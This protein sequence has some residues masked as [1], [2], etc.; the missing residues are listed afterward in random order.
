MKN[1]PIIAAVISMLMLCSCGKTKV[2]LQESITVPQT[3]STTASEVAEITETET[4]SKAAEATETETTSETVTSE[5]LMEI[6]NYDMIP[7]VE[8]ATYREPPAA[9]IPENMEFT[10]DLKDI[11]P[12][13]DLFA[14]TNME[15]H[16][17]GETFKMD[18][19]GDGVEEEISVDED[20]YKIEGKLRVLKVIIDGKTYN[21]DRSHEGFMNVPTGIFTCDIDSSD[22]YIEIACAG[23]IATNDYLTV[24]FRY[25]NGE[26]REIFDIRYDTPDGSGESDMF[27]D[28]MNQSVTGKPIITDGSGV[29]TAARRLDAQTWLAYSHYAYDSESGEISFF[30]EPVY[31]YYY[32]NINSF[33]M[34]MEFTSEWYIPDVVPERPMPKSLKEITLY[35]EP[36]LNSETVTLEPQECYITAEYFSFD[37]A[38]IYL[39]AKDGK[40]GW[41][42]LDETIYDVYSGLVLY[43]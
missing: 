1:K 37:G 17:I 15:K 13:T 12:E 38:W 25:E 16:S 43:D 42:N 35:K 28:K 41:C 9:I 3:E 22:N 31:P 21:I 20:F 34:A 11:T 10:L 24:F 5:T 32:E 4:V 7:M 2:D 26:L 8:R 18:L 19:D 23:S 14:L 29:I 39:A 40:S 27:F 6:S 30:C 36:D 33:D